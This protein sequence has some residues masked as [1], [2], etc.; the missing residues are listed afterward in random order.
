M[1][2]SKKFT[3]KYPL[4][5]KASLSTIYKKIDNDIVEYYY[6]ILIIEHYDYIYK[7]KNNSNIYSKS[8][9]LFDGFKNELKRL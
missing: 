9:I 2:K 1:E 7:Y 3:E 6:E 4:F 8:K 5:L